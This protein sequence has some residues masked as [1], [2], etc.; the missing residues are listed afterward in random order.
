[1]LALQQELDEIQGE[2]EVLNRDLTERERQLSEDELKAGPPARRPERVRGKYNATAQEA[3]VS[4]K[5]E[6][7][8]VA[9]QQQLTEEMKKVL[10]AEFRRAPQDAV[11]AC[12]STANT[13]S[14]SSTLRAAWPITRG[15]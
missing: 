4:N 5:L 10:G 14:S 12:R 13:S 9:A 6:G 15:R 7:Q 1:M 11:A 8:L 2:T 3:E